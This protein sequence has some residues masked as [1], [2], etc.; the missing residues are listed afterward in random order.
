[1]SWNYRVVNNIANEPPD[2]IYFN[3][4][5]NSSSLLGD[6]CNDSVSHRKDSVPQSVANEELNVEFEP[7]AQ[8][9]PAHLPKLPPSRR[10][11]AKRL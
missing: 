6:Q 10:G 2:V 11:G 8:P 5:S 3:P 1:M 9:E 7:L 4:V